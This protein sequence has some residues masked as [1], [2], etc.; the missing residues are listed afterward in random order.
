MNE[1]AMAALEEKLT[2]QSS[3]DADHPISLTIKKTHFEQ[4]AA[5][6]LLPSFVRKLQS[7]MRVDGVGVFQLFGI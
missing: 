5:K 4:G 6:T 1:A 3:S 7:G 2:A